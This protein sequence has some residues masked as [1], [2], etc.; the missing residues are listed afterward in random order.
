LLAV[1]IVS[2]CD[3]G[4]N[5]PPV[6]ASGSAGNRNEKNPARF[7]PISG[8]T[9]LALDTQT[10][11]LCQTFKKDDSLPTCVSIYRSNDGLEDRLRSSPCASGNFKTAEELWQCL[12]KDPACLP[13]RIKTAEQLLKCHGM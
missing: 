5:V 8:T 11:Q 4:K 9:A 7:I 3:S 13:G 10:G 12:G 6:Q 1:L 2:G